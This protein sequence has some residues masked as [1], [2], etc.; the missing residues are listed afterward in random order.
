DEF[1]VAEP[2]VQKTGNDRITVEL[3]G[4]EDRE[5]ATEVVQR[6]AFL[7]FQI[8]DKTQALERAIPRLDA[9]A[10]DRGL[11]A[12]APDARADTGRTNPLGGL[13]QNA[14]SAGADTAATVLDGPFRR[15]IQ[16]GNMP[17][18]YMV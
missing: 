16:A 6:S 15:S 3:P 18:Q 12:R 10:R 1:G 17:G 9:I 5:R 2:I 7:R 8:T 4:I 14:D 13:F 11:L